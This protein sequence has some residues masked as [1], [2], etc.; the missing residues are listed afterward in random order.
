MD[1][2]IADATI[3]SK[4]RSKR[5]VEVPLDFPHPGR[6]AGTALFYTV[7]NV[8]PSTFARFRAEGKIPQPIRHGRKCAWRESLMAELRDKGVA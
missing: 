3:T 6:V 5:T 8:A 1:T 4:R 7:L 2:D